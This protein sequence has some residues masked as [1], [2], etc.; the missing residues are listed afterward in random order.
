MINEK[1]K[2]HWIKTF[3]ILINVVLLQVIE[4]NL[5]TLSTTTVLTR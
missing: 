3:F 5:K 4:L 1:N 2:D